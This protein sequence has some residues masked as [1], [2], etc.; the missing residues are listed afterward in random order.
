MSELSMRRLLSGRY[1]FKRGDERV[2][3][4]DMQY[5]KVANL[6][7][8]AEDLLAALTEVL[9]SIDNNLPINAANIRDAIAKAKGATA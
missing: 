5:G 3:V 6:F 7:D 2:A 1:E 4:V 9:E 8:A